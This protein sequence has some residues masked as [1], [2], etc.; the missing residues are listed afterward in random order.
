M[1]PFQ[2]LP[3]ELGL[4]I[5]ESAHSPKDAARLSHASPTL[6]RVR[7]AH[8]STI[9]THI[10]QK[11]LRGIYTP[12]F[13]QDAMAVI[14]FPPR[15]TDSVRTRWKHVKKHKRCW[16]A[17]RFPNPIDEQDLGTMKQLYKLYKQLRRYINDYL[18]KATSP[19]LHRAYFRLPLW[20]SI[21]RSKCDYLPL[22]P[23]RQLDLE[24][25][26]AM[27]KHRF[28]KAFLRFELNSR[29]YTAKIWEES[30]SILAAT[31]KRPRDIGL[32]CL[33]SWKRLNNMEGTIPSPV[34]KESMRCVFEYVAC[35]YGMLGAR[36]LKHD[37]PNRSVRGGATRPAI[38]GDHNV[39]FSAR[40]FLGGHC[41]V[42]TLV[43]GGFDQ[44]DQLLT[45][46]IYAVERFIL[47][48]TPSSIGFWPFE[49]D[50]VD[51]DLD[52][53]LEED[54]I[55]EGPGLWAR[56]SM[57]KE[58]DLG[59]ADFSN[60]QHVISILKRE[61]ARSYRQRAWAFFDDERWYPDPCVFPTLVTLSQALNG[62]WWSFTTYH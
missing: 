58:N 27:E 49:S 32:S 23:G 7:L 43:F 25:L 14:R 52:I 18:S 33:W 60:C 62:Q 48:K 57:E 31:G 1:D 36:A 46:D 11:R 35:L 10:L 26:P 40:T 39:S 29:L 5:L 47:P 53:Y 3:C 16:A 37:N 45:R 8:R 21:E 61:V 2:H 20:S 19:N 24:S 17:K 34:E 12:D 9:D 59:H 51:M 22:P 28:L 55:L 15:E 38:L 41:Q 54:G 44:L 6:L 30:D 13:L 50:C 56:L 4:E 42:G